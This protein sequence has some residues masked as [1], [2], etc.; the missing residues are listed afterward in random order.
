[1][2]ENTK[3][4]PKTENAPITTHSETTT[5]CNS[6]HINGNNRL[7]T[8]RAQETALPMALT[9]IQTLAT[10]QRPQH[11]TKNSNKCQRHAKCR[12]N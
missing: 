7:L 1:M 8:Q 3:K 4:T 12:A 11:A 5:T 10:K 2:G 9:V 6:A